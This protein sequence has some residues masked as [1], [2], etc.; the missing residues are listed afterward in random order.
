MTKRTYA[1]PRSHVGL[2][3]RDAEATLKWYELV[4]GFERLAEP[5]S[6]YRY[7]S[8]YEDVSTL[9]GV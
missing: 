4:L 9:L 5:Y 1:R 3:V 6:V 2:T 7:D 8:E